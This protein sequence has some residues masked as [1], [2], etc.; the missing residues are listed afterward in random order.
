[1]AD[2]LRIIPLGGLGEVGKNMMVLEYGRNILIID[3][4]V[5]FPEND[6]LGIDLVI[7]DFGYL[8]DKSDLVRGI[9]LT[10]GHMDHTG[11]LPYLLREIETPIYATRLTCGLIRGM[12]A[13]HNLLAGADLNRVQ[14]GE[15]VPIGPFEV[16]FFAVNHSLPDAAGLAIHTPVG[17]VVHSGDFKLGLTPLGE[18][19][20]RL[21]DLAG[22]AEVGVMVLLSDSTGSESPGFTPSEQL[23]EDGFDEIFR[24]APGR[25]IIA[26]FASLISRIQLAVDAAA[27]YGRRIA[28]AGRSMRESV[29]I[30]QE[31]GHLRIPSGLLMNIRQMSTLPSSRVVILATGSQGEPRSAL[32]QMSRN[33]H[34]EIKVQPGDTVIL[35]TS[36]IPGNEEA[37][38]RVIN[39]LL[40]Q[41]AHVLYEAIAPVHVSGHGS[42]EDQK[43]LL[44]LL[45]PLFFVPI[46]GELRHLHQH[47]RLAQEMGLPD[48]RILVVENGQVLEF[49]GKQG[50]VRERIP[51]GYVFVDGASVGEV[52]PAVVRERETLS[53]NGFVVVAVQ[54]AAQTKQLVAEPQIVSH[55][56]VY[57]RESEELMDEAK[58]VVA[59]AVRAARGEESAIADKVVHALEEYLYRETGRHPMVIP[60]VMAG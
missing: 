6:M 51:G 30:A 35:S 56:F 9:V 42:Q 3:A 28:I 34:R 27:R 47:A 39:R 7:P 45:E 36:V 4:G 55:G 44:K 16:E 43:L 23:V 54:L 46:H 37:V 5:M 50:H 49:D 52:G 59:T 53:Q 22:L 58:E 32:A 17:L 29:V 2:T 26:S 19:G 40:H 13:E 21:A 25:I 48:E 12:L 38:G 41:G 14:A 20:P 8:R 15:A 18:P 60:I 11:A 24:K 1:M 31:Q 57:A 33:R 10:H